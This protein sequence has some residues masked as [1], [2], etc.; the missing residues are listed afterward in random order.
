VQVIAH[1]DFDAF[2][3][4]VEMRLRPAL[5][6]RPVVVAGSG[7]RAVV[8]AA[9]Y[10]ARSFGVR[11]GQPL[12]QARALCRD[13][14]VVTPRVAAYRLV[15]E[16][17]FSCVSDLVEVLEVVGLD[18][19]FAL[20]G[21]PSPGSVVADGTAALPVVAATWAED[22]RDR[23]RAELGLPLSVGVGSS[24]TVAKLA[25]M[26]AKPDGV[27]VV[28]P[29]EESEFLAGT[30]LRDVPGVGPR[31]SETLASLGL[32][33]LG[34]VASFD[35]RVLRSRLGARSSEWL[36]GLAAG[37]DD[38]RVVPASRRAQVGVSRTFDQDLSIEQLPVDEILVEV[39]RRLEA[40]G[41]ATALLTLR[42]VSAA[43][44]GSF[45]VRLS[46]TRDVSSLAA[47]ARAAVS[48]LPVGPFRSLG[49]T[50]SALYDDEQ[51]VLPGL[52]T[53]EQ[54]VLPPAPVPGLLECAYFS[55]PVRHAVYGTG[56]LEAVLDGGQ[57]VIPED[58]LCR[59]R[60]DRPRLIEASRLTMIDP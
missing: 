33:R 47:V 22:L 2:F 44:E 51:L 36:R 21:L 11:S 54:V 32:E 4:S 45:S 29:V 58:A 28:A 20:V 12:F 35:D 53:S 50:F 23:V 9:S 16:R 41:R 56:R 14:V 39:L 26:A 18:E 40:D 46:P 42:F 25:S 19:A 57:A 24:K 7:P 15:S 49:L 59:V 10:P 27:R 17:A 5:A 34:D 48:R 8:A 60:F 38:R 3:A 31:A 55:M 30:A 1:L 6:R 52:L 37:V 13:L 43:G